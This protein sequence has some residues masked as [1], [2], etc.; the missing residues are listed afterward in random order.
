MF[1]EDLRIDPELVDLDFVG[2][3]DHAAEEIGRC[4]RDLGD[5]LAQLSARAR[6]GY[7]DRSVVVGQQLSDHR[8]KRVVVAAEDVFPD[9][10]FQIAHHRLRLSRLRPDGSRPSAITRSSM[11]LG[12]GR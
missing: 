5:R 12:D 7:R 4:P 8:L 9:H 6:F 10:R 2:V 3:G 11:L 1:F